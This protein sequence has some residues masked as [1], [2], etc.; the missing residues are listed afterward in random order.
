MNELKIATV[1]LE[2][3]T[4]IC[5]GKSNVSVTSWHELKEDILNFLN[6]SNIDISDY[7]IEKVK[8]VF[9]Q[10]ETNKQ[11]ISENSILKR[12]NETLAT[13]NL[14]LKKQNIKYS[15]AFRGIK[16]IFSELNKQSTINEASV[17]DA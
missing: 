15:Q 11:L 14:R 8:K 16:S 3:V 2:R 12:K 7:R 17:K 5:R 10:T 1:L 13:E 4:T 9:M 6:N